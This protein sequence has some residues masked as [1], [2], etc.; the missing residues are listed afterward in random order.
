[1][2]KKK[3][4]LDQSR[5]Q[6]RNKGKKEK[7][8]RRDVRPRGFEET[9]AVWLSTLAPPEMSVPVRDGPVTEEMPCWWW[10]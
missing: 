5:A 8:K 10:S 4:R 1:V 3:R 7:E 6:V 9:P 2:E